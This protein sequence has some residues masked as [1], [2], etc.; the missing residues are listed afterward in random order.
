MVLKRSFMLGGKAVISNVKLG[1][2]S[3]SNKI[4]RSLFLLLVIYNCKT[5]LHF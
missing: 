2:L 5:A 1:Q 3:N 4:F